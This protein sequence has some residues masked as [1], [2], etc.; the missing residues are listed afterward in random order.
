MFNFSCS[1]SLYLS[2][3]DLNDAGVAVIADCHRLSLLVKFRVSILHDYGEDNGINT[4]FT[5][6]YIAAKIDLLVL[7]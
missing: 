2:S 5:L 7:F 4:S 3:H 6:V 1:F